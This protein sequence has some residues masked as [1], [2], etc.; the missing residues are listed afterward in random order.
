M[1]VTRS[2]RGMSFAFLPESPSSASNSLQGD[3][4]YFLKRGL[5]WMHMAFDPATLLQEVTLHFTSTHGKWHSSYVYIQHRELYLV[6]YDGT[7]CGIMW[8]KECVYIY[9]CVTGSLCYTVEIERTL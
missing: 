5:F 9:M 4:T 2:F 8:E 3:P 7:W 6:T 1:N